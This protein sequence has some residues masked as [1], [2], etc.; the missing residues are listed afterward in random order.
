MALHSEK[1][2]RTQQGDPGSKAHRSPGVSKSPPFVRFPNPMSLCSI[3]AQITSPVLQQPFAVCRSQR[4]HDPK[5]RPLYYFL[6]PPFYTPP[7]GSRGV[8]LQRPVGK[9]NICLLGINVGLGLFSQSRK[10]CLADILNFFQS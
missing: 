6:I 10:Q 1:G 9:R 4:N 7:L 5:I 3:P 8:C 2:E